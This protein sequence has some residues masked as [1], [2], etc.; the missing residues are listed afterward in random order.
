[1]LTICLLGKLTLKNTQRELY[2]VRAQWKNIGIQLDIHMGT[3]NVV[4]ERCRGDPDKCLPDM[5]DHWLKQVDPPPSWEALAE[6]LES[7]PVGEGRLAEEI[8]QKYCSQS[9]TCT[10]LSSRGI[11]QLQPLTGVLKYS[12]HL[13]CMYSRSQVV[14][15]NKWPPSPS[16]RYINLACIDKQ[17][18]NRHEADKFTKSTIQGNI[19]DIYHKKIQI[20]MEQVA[21]TELKQEKCKDSLAI[22]VKKV[23][24]RIVLVEGAPGV[25]KTTFAWELCRRWAQGELLQDY[26]L[27][28]LLRMRDCTAS[29]ATELV[30]LFP[31]PQKSFSQSLIDEIL[32][33]NGKEVL[34]LLEGFDELVEDKRIGYSSVYHELIKGR[35]L[36]SSTVL[37]TSRPWAVSDVRQRHSQRIDQRIEILGFTRQQ[38]DDFLISYCGDDQKLLDDMHRYVSLNPPIHA[39]M[40]IPLNTVIVCEIYKDRQNRD[41]IVPTTMTKL[42]T[43]FSLTLLIRYLDDQ[44]QKP[45]KLKKFEDLPPVVNEKFLAVCKLASDGISNNQQLIFSNLPDDFETLG[46]MQSDPELHI[47]SGVSVSYNFLHLTIQEFLAAYYLSLQPER[48]LEV[49]APSSM[50]LS[51]ADTIK[52]FLAGITKLMDNR[53]SK[54]LPVPRSKQSIAAISIKPRILTFAQPPALKSYD[55]SF[56]D[57][58]FHACCLVFPPTC[59]VKTTFSHT[60]PQTKKISEY[61]KVECHVSLGGTASHCSWLYESQNI[62]MVHTCLGNKTAFIQIT[63]EMTP[64][65]CFAAGWCMRAGICEWKLYFVSEEAYELD[66]IEML[67]AGVQCAQNLF[68][69]KRKHRICELCICQGIMNSDPTTQNVFFDFLGDHVDNIKIITIIILSDSFDSDLVCRFYARLASVI[70]ECALLKKIKLILPGNKS[71][72][73]YQKI[74]SM[75]NHVMNTLTHLSIQFRNRSRSDG[76]SCSRSDPVRILP[77]PGSM[78][79]TIDLTGTCLAGDDAIALVL[80]KSTNLKHLILEGCGLTCIRNITEELKVNKSLQTL[81]LSGN[82]LWSCGQCLAGMLKVNQILQILRLYEC[83]LTHDDTTSLFEVLKANQN[84]SL[85]TLCIG[86]NSFRLQCL[87]EMISSNASLQCIEVTVPYIISTWN[88]SEK[89]RYQ[90]NADP[91]YTQ[92]ITE[93]QVEGALQWEIL[94]DLLQDSA[95][96][97]FES[98]QLTW[99]TNDL[100]LQSEMQSVYNIMRKDSV[101]QTIVSAMNKNTTLRC[102]VIH[103]VLSEAAI[104]SRFSQCHDYERVREIIKVAST[105]TAVPHNNCHICSR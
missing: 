30:D 6:A 103:T 32:M 34:I 101:Y 2:H 82:Y 4:D 89:Y 38:I 27:V 80:W 84:T 29:K 17:S 86:D 100:N 41:C 104:C 19:D 56:P 70:Q 48:D 42:Y 87:G 91:F 72:V 73:V 57:S 47:S 75:L 15:D 16:T 92:D 53:L 54:C 36:P 49:S 99:S 9:D 81:D 51:S 5:L 21:C 44:G 98:E 63:I 60:R 43:A 1:L 83:G 22:E 52:E 85:R 26:S 66:C 90:D 78:L 33:I 12:K 79:L 7:A 68:T 94:S 28:V 31:Y 74:T 65:Q 11:Q 50:L 97:D 40:Y 25:G 23:F 35:L 3:L 95:S 8:R 10:T 62:D 105:Q 102:L 55:S 18:V 76:H 67:Q 71:K 77:Y 37:I 46:F 20:F 96:F 39:A 45:K 88:K 13:K 59:A 69:L 24:P 93:G 64:M 58:S 14:P 61:I